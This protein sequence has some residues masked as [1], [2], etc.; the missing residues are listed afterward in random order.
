LIFADKLRVEAGEEL[1]AL[2][3]QAI[4]DTYRRDETTLTRGAAEDTHLSP[5]RTAEVQSLAQFMVNEVR[6]M[7][8][9]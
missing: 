8:R 9:L 1:L 7:C 3:A 2:T 5:E 6:A 4:N